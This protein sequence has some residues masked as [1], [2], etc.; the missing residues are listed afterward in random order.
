M[1]VR[2]QLVTTPRELDAQQTNRRKFLKLATAIGGAVAAVLGGIPALRAFTSPLFRL[3]PRQSWIKLGEV[4]FFEI[5]VPTKFDFVQTVVD[6]WVES[7]VLRNVWIYTDDGVNF[8][9]YS[10]RCTHLGCSY[11]FDEEKEAFRCPC[12]EGVFDLKTGRVLGGP[13]PR[14]LDQLEVKTE[15]GVLFAAYQDFRLGVP[16]KIP[17]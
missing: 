1:G 6:A 8:T 16:G 14:A 4:D 5:G 7:R 12:H 11:G 3:Q 2:P 10:G 9:A 17:V 13:P 15:N